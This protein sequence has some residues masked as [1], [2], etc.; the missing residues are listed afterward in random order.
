[1]AKDKAFMGVAAVGGLGLGYALSKLM[2]GKAAADLE[3]VA[4]NLFVS[5]APLVP[6][7]WLDRKFLFSH[8][9]AG[10]PAALYAF[11]YSDGITHFNN[12][13]VIVSVSAKGD[14]T[15]GIECAQ[16]AG[17]GYRVYYNG[18]PKIILTDAMAHQVFWV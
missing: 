6:Q 4:V 9:N 17:P 2:G 12:P 15:Y 13:E 8:T 1:M 3:A 18:L 7:S 5:R 10:M 16:F 14:G 11:C